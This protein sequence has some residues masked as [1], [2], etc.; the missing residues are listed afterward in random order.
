MRRNIKASDSD[1]YKVSVNFA[2][3]IGADNEYYVYADSEEEAELAAIEE[4]KDDLEII[5]ID[6]NGDG[7]YT[8]TVGFGGFIGVEELVEVV[9]DSEEEAEELVY[10]EA[11]MSF[12]TA[13]IVD[14]MSDLEDWQ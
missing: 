11:A 4:A 14:D 3:Y 1:E 2:G 8:A 13:E 9:A 5:S 12:L 7:S 6:D 10:D